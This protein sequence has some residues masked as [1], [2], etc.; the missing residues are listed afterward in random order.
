MFLEIDCNKIIIIR[1]LD[2]K[3]ISVF[4][5]N[6]FRHQIKFKFSKG[7]I[8][9]YIFLNT[10]SNIKISDGTLKIVAFINIKLNVGNV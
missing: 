4:G 2:I 10:I 5:Q 8:C 9:S 1:C 7:K 3:V 6:C